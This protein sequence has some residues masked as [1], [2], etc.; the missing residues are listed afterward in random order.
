MM[1]FKKFFILVLQKKEIFN[2]LRIHKL[3]FTM[4][5]NNTYAY[6]PATKPDDHAH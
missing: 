2:L 4:F 5:R 6:C 3:Q 1:N